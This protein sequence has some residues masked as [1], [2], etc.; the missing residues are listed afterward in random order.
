ML[1]TKI[2]EER[3]SKYN[4]HLR[5]VK[6]LGLGTYIQ[7]E[8]LTQSGG[9]VEDIWKQ[10]LKRIYNLK[11]TINNCLILGL[12]GGTAAKLVRKKWSGAKITGIDIDPI[13][14]ELGRKYLGL[15]EVGLDIKVED[16]LETVEK[17]KRKN[18][19]FDLIIVD[20]YNGDQF[21]EKFENENY[22]HLVR[23]ILARSGVAIFNQLYYDDKRSNTIRFGL[24]LQKVF[25][26]VEYYYP[27]ANLMFLCYNK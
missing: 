20:L 8:G 17:L 10:T 1:G 19:K 4:G 11:F 9:I 15:D 3:D 13:M 24:K 2:L 7:A 22:M 26:R 5:V 16:A 18:E 23:N 6:T 21:P 27:E 14:I 12:G 25:S